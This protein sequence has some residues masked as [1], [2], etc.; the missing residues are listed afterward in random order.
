MNQPERGGDRLSPGQVR[1]LDPVCDRFEAEWLA[2]RRPHL[3]DFLS[4]VAEPDRPALVR[5]LLPLDLEYRAR[6]GERPAAREYHARLPVYAAV[7]DGVFADLTSPGL[8]DLPS[9]PPPTETVASAAGRGALLDEP[10]PA[11]VGRYEILEEIAR[12]GMGVVLRAR[13]PDLQRILAVKVL[14]EEHRGNA[15]LGRR[16]RVEAQL[17]GLLQHPGIPP[18]HEVGALDDGRPFF[19]M[20]LIEGLTLAEVLERRS[21]ADLPV[22]VA[23]FKQVCQTLAYAHSKGVIHR[24]LKPSNVM[25]GAFG[26]VQVM[27]WGL[28]K[29]LGDPRPAPRKNSEHPSLIAPM[30]AAAAGLTSQP[31]AVLGT[32]A[33]MAPEQAR[34]E[35][36][37]VDE[38][39]DVFG[40]GAMLCEV[41]TGQPPY[42][43]STVPVL[44]RAMLGDLDQAVERLDGCG[45]DPELVGL[46][47]ACLAA[48]PEDRLPHGG[49]VAEAVS[50][51]LNGV[52]EKLRRAEL[53][54]AAAALRAVEE[55]KQRR[56]KATLA[57]VG[58]AAML[59]TG[60]GLLWTKQAREAQTAVLVDEDLGRAASLRDQAVKLRLSDAGQRQESARLWKDALDAADDAEKDLASG[61]ASPLTKRRFDEMVPPLRDEAREV[62]R[63]RDM[64]E[65]LEEARERRAAIAD[66]DLDRTDPRAI[67]VFGHS[68]AESYATAFRDYDIDVLALEP[69]EA[70]R[71][72]QER[73]RISDRLVEALDD[74]LALDVQQAASPFLLAVSRAA[75]PDPFRNHLRAAVAAVDRDALKQ[76]AD[77]AKARE[78][79]VPAALLLA[80][81]LHLAGEL[82]QAVE[83]LRR[84]REAHP[85]DFWVNDV[86]GVYLFGWDPSRAD[87]A[88]RCFQA[89]LAL[90]PNSYFVY[91]NLALTLIWQCRWPEAVAEC[92]RAQEKAKELHRDFH[93]VRFTLAVARALQGE[94]DKAIA[95]CRDVV[96]R[97]P[98][99][100]FARVELMRHLV[101]AGDKAAALDLA[102]E[103]VARNKGRP[104][105]YFG[106]AEALSWNGKAEQA[107]AA[108]EEAR[109]LGWNPF[110][111]HLGLGYAYLAHNNVAEA[112]KH[113]AEA[114]R[115]NPHR[116][117][118]L[119]GLGRLSALERRWEEAVSTCRRAVALR[120]AFWQY[121]AILGDL[122]FHAGAL[123]EAGTAY[124]ETLRLNPKAEAA[125]NGLGNVLERTGDWDRAV[126]EYQ[127]ALRLHP[128]AAVYRKVGNLQLLKGRPDDALAAFEKA[129]AM[130]PDNADLR[131]ACCDARGLVLLARKEPARAIDAFRAAV[132]AADGNARYWM[133][134]GRA[135]WHNGD[136]RQRDEAYREA[137]RRAGKDAFMLGDLGRDLVAQEAYEDA[138]PVLRRALDLNRKYPFGL[139]QFGL[140][141]KGAGSYDEAIAAFRQALA[142]EPGNVSFLDN[143]GVALIWSGRWT[144]AVAVL[145]QAVQ[146]SERFEAA[147]YHL[148]DALRFAGRFREGL[149]AF[150]KGQALSRER[151]ADPFAA[152]IRLCA[153]LAALESRRPAVLGGKVLPA[154]SEEGFDLAVFC[155]WTGHP[156]PAAAYFTR[157]FEV[158]GIENNAFQGA[159]TWSLA[160]RSRCGLSPA[161]GPALYLLGLAECAFAGQ[162]RAA[163]R[164]GYRFGAALAALAAA[165]EAGGDEPARLRRQALA[166]MR[167]EVLERPARQAADRL[168]LRR[169]LLR[170]Q[171][172]AGLA[173]VRDRAAL[174]NLPAAER[175]EWL[176][177]WADVDAFVQ[178]KGNGK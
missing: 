34:G 28:A 115:L 169:E 99:F 129:C 95:I 153:R 4:Q 124:R 144:E 154:T 103:T 57:A 112:R 72:I 150:E 114:L 92:Q 71:R 79:P 45:A 41:L 121:Q 68:A 9:T 52:Q 132:E 63:D 16:F 166:W 162:A 55:R 117:E 87:E 139:N 140:A 62:A 83:L 146:S 133:H 122:L 54:R 172:H 177:F 75:D 19:A 159:T 18:V 69:Q 60:I 51:Y 174:A 148:G 136:S 111:V 100:L 82:G 110:D 14:K 46:A 141:L 78:L 105:A 56:L 1:R 109:H 113:F 80:D 15:D 149:A 135:C 20:K 161:G 106:L 118:V 173:G 145:Q 65:R 102:R 96:R 176:Q 97:K 152:T 5:E 30:P 165:G 116:P 164:Q 48:E 58:L 39:A 157:A 66:Q 167:A 98:D 36:D 42:T 175:R 158:M 84:T 93:K 35:V 127:K 29:V 59:L 86:L 25:V 24:D 178:D 130:I 138:I 37:R 91:D 125:H 12:G 170:W 74:W 143:L 70:A 126:A 89:A 171:N 32:P 77:E 119:L 137:V 38:R 27:D 6:H 2:G 53:D 73:K 43:G 156:V 44:Y 85:D 33:Y 120:P 50:A 123:D 23:V 3:E 64:V 168:L 13:D 47:R 104:L 101:G 67:V 151:G 107:V 155:F 26:D 11:R 22:L 160:A 10:L 31:G 131:A 90:R 17:T 147:W 128:S 81:G 40:L 163:A 61:L 134:L 142:L 7:I 21:A 94:H 76:L 108:Y 8:P 49:A 88:G